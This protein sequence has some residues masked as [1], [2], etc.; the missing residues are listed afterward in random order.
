MVSPIWFSLQASLAHSDTAHFLSLVR[1]RYEKCVVCIFAFDKALCFF[2]RIKWSRIWL[3]K[4][5]IKM[6]LNSRSSAIFDNFL[7]VKCIINW[8]ICF[9]IWNHCILINI[10]LITLWNS[11]RWCINCKDNGRNQ[12]D[13]QNHKDYQEDNCSLLIT[14]FFRFISPKIWNF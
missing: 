4:S 7:I 1:N 11:S 13:K 14:F 10:P 9:I 3:N 8:F 6:N 5:I 2:W 12:I